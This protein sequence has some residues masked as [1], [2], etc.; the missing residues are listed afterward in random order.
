MLN[1]S[2][3]ELT[4][5]ENTYVAGVIDCDRDGLLYTS[6]PQNGNWTAEVDGESAQIV[7]VGDCM[8]G[9]YLTEGTHA[10]S[11]SYHNAAFSLGAKITALCVIV[12]AALVYWIYKPRLPRGKYEK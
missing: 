8:I 7:L 10:V 6:I 11:F 1:A 5:F 12:F 9:L 3:L 2:T 4:K